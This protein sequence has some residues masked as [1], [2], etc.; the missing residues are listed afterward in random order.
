MKT[1]LVLFGFMGAGK[2]TVG[3][4]IA[5]L[6]EMEFVDTDAIIEDLEGVS[7]DEVFQ[8]RGET[9][10]RQRERDIVKDVARGNNTVIA[11]GGGVPLDFRN[12]EALDEKGLGV[13]LMVSAPDVVA[14]IKD[15][16]NRPLLKGG[17]DVGRVQSLLSQR[18]DAYGRLRHRVDTSRLTV[19]QVAAKVWELF[20][21][22][23]GKAPA[24]AKG[25]VKTR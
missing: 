18:R 15:V 24:A 20:V 23:R 13:L 22:E 3:K 2:S 16:D 14:R 12:L 4:R 7:I 8:A 9:A 10:F 11:T 5:E 1:N 25:A 19:D 17:M 6:H 21:R